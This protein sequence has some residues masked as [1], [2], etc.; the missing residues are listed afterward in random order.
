MLTNKHTSHTIHMEALDK[1]AEG[2]KLDWD[3]E[4]LTAEHI[5]EMEKYNKYAL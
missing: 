2:N 1:Y 5:K 3:A 4:K